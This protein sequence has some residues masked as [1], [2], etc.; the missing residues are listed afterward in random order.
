MTI[1]DVIRRANER[2]QTSQ[3]K[4]MPKGQT[5]LIGADRLKTPTTLDR[6]PDRWNISHGG[7][8]G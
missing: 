7:M 1:L 8:A 4:P 2:W 5:E 6:A 3:H